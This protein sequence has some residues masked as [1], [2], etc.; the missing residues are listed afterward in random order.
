MNLSASFKLA[1]SAGSHC[2]VLPDVENDAEDIVE[3]P[4]DDN[5]RG[6]KV[7]VHSY[8]WQ[9]GGRTEVWFTIFQVGEV[10]DPLCAVLWNHED[11][12]LESLLAKKY[13]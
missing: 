4:F 9:T 1:F 10:Q 7:A 2:S 12:L 13:E 11:V 5:V 6:E 3:N 8:K